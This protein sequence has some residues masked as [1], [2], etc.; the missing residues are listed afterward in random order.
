MAKYP[1]TTGKQHRSLLEE[2]QRIII[3]VLVTVIIVIY[4]ISF[5][6]S[7]YKAQPKILA[8]EIQKPTLWM[9][10]E[11]TVKPKKHRKY[12]GNNA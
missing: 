12:G 1:S 6:T 7:G 3:D 8:P 5:Q 11:S 4:V 2:S 10:P 9:R